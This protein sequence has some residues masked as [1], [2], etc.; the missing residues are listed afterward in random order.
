MC[1][2][3]HFFCYQQ[4]QCLV[5]TAT[6]RGCGCGCGSA[7][8]RI[9]QQRTASAAAATR[10]LSRLRWASTNGQSSAVIPLSPWVCVCVCVGYSSYGC[11]MCVSRARICGASCA[12]SAAS[13]SRLRHPRPQ[14]SDGSASE[15]VRASFQVLA[16]QARVRESREQTSRCSR[17]AK[18]CSTSIL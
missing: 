17:R 12:L 18:G 5:I 3:C 4:R 13:V 8:G 7:S 1:L 9:Q 16:A 11:S 10:Q 2:G 15:F 14:K 6:G